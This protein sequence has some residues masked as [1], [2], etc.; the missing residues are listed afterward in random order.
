L[1]SLNTTRQ[2]PLFG[3]SGNAP[4]PGA[5]E[6]G[7]QA[8]APSAVTVAIVMH[9]KA[10][11]IRSIARMTP[12]ATGGVLLSSSYHGSGCRKT[13]AQLNALAASSPS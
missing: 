12:P 7:L 1:R 4:A 10:L 2:S 5:T 6:I 13:T 8:A 11:D 3:H 9:R